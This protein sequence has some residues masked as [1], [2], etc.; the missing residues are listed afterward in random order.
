MLNLMSGLS[1]PLKPITKQDSLAMEFRLLFTHIV[2][3]RASANRLYLQWGAKAQLK[4][5]F[6]SGLIIQIGLDNHL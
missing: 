2:G 1:F 4:E 6:Q 5:Q 3:P